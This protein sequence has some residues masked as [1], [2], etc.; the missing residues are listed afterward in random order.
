MSYF[1]DRTDKDVFNPV[2]GEGDARRRS[3]ELNDKYAGKD[4]TPSEET[5]L[6]RRITPSTTTAASRSFP[7]ARWSPSAFSAT[8]SRS[9]V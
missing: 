8:A 4:N 5:S 1:D 6:P 2:H 3:Y 7:R 9:W